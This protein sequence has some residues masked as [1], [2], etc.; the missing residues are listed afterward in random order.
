IV[1]ICM[2]EPAQ[3]D[4]SMNNLQQVPRLAEGN[5][6]EV[7]RQARQVV[8]GATRWS[9]RWSSHRRRDAWFLLLSLLIGS[10]VIVTL[11]GG[12]SRHGELSRLER[13]LHQHRLR[14]PLPPPLRQPVPFTSIHSR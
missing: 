8:P 13:L 10:I 9:A 14:P 11:S 5:K 1:S 12:I 6:E 3:S 4:G 2:I 7:S